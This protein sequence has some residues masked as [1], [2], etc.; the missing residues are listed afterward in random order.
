M[1]TSKPPSTFISD[2]RRSRVATIEAEVVQLDEPREVPTRDGGKT[3][4]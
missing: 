2:L 4:E 3:K 1:P